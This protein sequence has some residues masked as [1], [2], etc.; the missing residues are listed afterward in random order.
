MYEYEL[1][2]IYNE[3]VWVEGELKK[4]ELNKKAK[5]H[6]WDDLEAFIGSYVDAFGSITVEIKMKEVSLDA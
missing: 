4:A 1:K 5:F 3:Y 6:N 2:L